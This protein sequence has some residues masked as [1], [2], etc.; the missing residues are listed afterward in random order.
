[1]AGLSVFTFKC[2]SLL[3][4][5]ETCGQDQEVKNNLKMLFH[6]DD[7]PCDTQMRKRLDSLSP[8]GVTS[9]FHMPI[10]AVATR[11][12]IGALPVFGYVFSDQFGWYRF[13]F[14]S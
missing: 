7:V 6:V 2:P 10:C 12:S 5:D 4:F 13:F 9:G 1:M 11:Q 3:Q 8:P 14:Q